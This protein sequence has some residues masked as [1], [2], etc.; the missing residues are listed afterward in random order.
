VLDILISISLIIIYT[1]GLKNDNHGKIS[2]FSNDTKIRVGANNEE[3]YKQIPKD[4][5][6]L[7]N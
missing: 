2:R 3:Q 4:L 6:Y 7:G 1:T 5:D